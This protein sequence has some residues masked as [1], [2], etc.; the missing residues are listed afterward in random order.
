MDTASS[1]TVLAVFEKHTT[2]APGRGSNMKVVRTV[3]G[4]VESKEVGIEMV[5]HLNSKPVDGRVYVVEPLPVFAEVTDLPAYKAEQDKLALQKKLDD[6]N[7]TPDQLAVL[8]KMLKE[9]NK[10]AE[11][12]AVPP[13]VEAT[14][15]TV[16]A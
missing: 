13:A 16:V 6:L 8:A 12:P 2:K 10:T 1:K 11:T 9:K 14:N 5:N 7:L 4:M 3:L 15:E